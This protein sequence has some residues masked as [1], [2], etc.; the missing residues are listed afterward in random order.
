MVNFDNYKSYRF[1]FIFAIRKYMK[2]ERN[3]QNLPRLENEIITKAEN[4]EI[5]INIRKKVTTRE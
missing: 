3:D 4:L 2:K 5:I 1:H